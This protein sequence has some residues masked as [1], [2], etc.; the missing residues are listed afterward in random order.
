MTEYEI[1]ACRAMISMNK[2]MRNQTEIDWEQR[3]FD[4]VKDLVLLG[5]GKDGFNGDVEKVIDF[6]I[7]IADKV[8]ERLKK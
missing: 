5:V 7:D 2:K 3:R 4:I 6:S 8:V 1:S